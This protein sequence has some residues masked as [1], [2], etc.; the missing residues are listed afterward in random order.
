MIVNVPGH[1]NAQLVISLS[2]GNYGVAI[3]ILVNITAFFFDKH[4]PLFLKIFY[5]GNKFYKEYSA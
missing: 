2:V 5:I 4:H 1:I 3:M